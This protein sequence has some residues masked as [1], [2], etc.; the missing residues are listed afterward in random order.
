VTYDGARSTVKLDE[1]A[2]AR[3]TVQAGDI[4]LGRLTGPAE[5]ST[6]KGDIR[7]TE[8]ARGTVTLRTDLGDITVGTPRGTSASLDAGTAHGR[9]TNSLTNT[10]G[11]AAAVTFHA[12][13]A[14]GDITARSL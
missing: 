10:E 8:A 12:T 2:A 13:T 11:T 7:V 14:H 5:I 1:A 3:L 9:I 6:R 4:T